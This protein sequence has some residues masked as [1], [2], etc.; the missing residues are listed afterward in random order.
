MTS[1]KI[2]IIMNINIYAFHTSL[3]LHQHKGLKLYITIHTKL[4]IKNTQKTYPNIKQYKLTILIIYIYICKT[5]HSFIG[6]HSWKRSVSSPDVAH[7]KQSSFRITR[8]RT[9]KMNSRY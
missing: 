3:G 9:S 8:T 1:T 6:K 7:D 5:K 4:Y 2:F